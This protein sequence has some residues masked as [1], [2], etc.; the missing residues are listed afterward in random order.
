[1]PRSAVGQNKEICRLKEE[2]EFLE[3]DRIT[4]KNLFYC[5]MPDISRKGF[6]KYFTNKDHPWKYQ[7]L[8]D[9]IK[10]I[11]SEDDCKADLC[12]QT[13]E[14][15]LTAYP[16]LIHGDRGTQHTGESCRQ[17]IR[18]YYIHQSMD[19]TVGRWES[20]RTE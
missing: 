6:Y 3:D 2:N 12:I 9:I 5:R 8:A 1:M 13:L 20:S 11:I 15:G 17:T 4:G 7:D 14:N 18:N 19:S 16:T 10:E